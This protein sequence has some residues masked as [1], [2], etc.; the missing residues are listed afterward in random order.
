SS[1]LTPAAMRPNEIILCRRVRR[2]RLSH[3]HVPAAQAVSAFRAAVNAVS[4]ATVTPGAPPI[5]QIDED[6]AVYYLT[7]C[8]FEEMLFFPFGNKDDLVDAVSR[9]YD[10]KPVPAVPYESHMLEPP[11]DNG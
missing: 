3:R 4:A 10:F 9:I 6:R 2:S 5:K 8:L 1:R 7:R 11:E